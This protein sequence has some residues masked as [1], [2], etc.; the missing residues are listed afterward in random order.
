MTIE[1]KTKIIH[2]ITIA[3]IETKD[4]ITAGDGKRHDI[5]HG[6]GALSTNTTCN[7]FE[8]LRRRQVPIAYIGRGKR[9][10]TF[11]AQLCKMIP[12]EVVIRGVAA[13][14]YV[15]R[16]NVL[17]HTR[18]HPPIVEY[19]YKTSGRKIGEIKLP[20]DDPLIFGKPGNDWHMYLPDKPIDEGYIGPLPLSKEELGILTC[21]LTQCRDVALKVFDI[22]STIWKEY[23]GTLLDLKIEFG[24][25]PG[26]NIVVADVIDC[27]SWR[28]IYDGKQLSK[29]GYRDG[30]DL[31]KVL[32][33]YRI[34]DALVSN[35][36][37]E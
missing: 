28:V 6:K 37:T 7:I 4:D 14:S 8:L 3:E 18:I 21:Q 13:G 11:Y 22:L 5:L 36:V 35:M 33:V 31:E 23:S 2:S 26:G 25:L 29:Q 27:D 10:N 15:K 9:K 32:E 34:A 24:I 16:N 20:C 30:D 1:G 12:V 17:N 19:Y